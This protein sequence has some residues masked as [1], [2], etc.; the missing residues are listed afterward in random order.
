MRDSRV[1]YAVRIGMHD[2]D[3]K[4]SITRLT[5][6]YRCPHS[7]LAE[8]DWRPHRMRQ[9]SRQQPPDSEGQQWR[10]PERAA[11][12]ARRVTR[13]SGST[14]TRARRRPR[15]SGSSRRRPAARPRPCRP[16]TT[17]WRARFQ[18]AAACSCARA[19]RPRPSAPRPRSR[20]RQARRAARPPAQERAPAPAGSAAAI[21][22]QLSDAAEALVAHISRLES[23]LA[24]SRKDRERLAAIE[25]ALGR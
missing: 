7:R 6:H 10:H 19:R 23:E 20:R 16:R 3:L 18:A 11:A 25:R 9:S 12:L 13:R 1:V 14:S 2:G 4:H 17:A 15:P 24:E 5:L 22:R 8:R 21:A